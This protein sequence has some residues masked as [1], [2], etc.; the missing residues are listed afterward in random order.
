MENTNER[1]VVRVKKP[2]MIGAA[3][4]LAAVGLQAT[5][6]TCASLTDTYAALQTAGSCTIGDKTFSDFTFSSATVT[7]TGLLFTTVNDVAGE[8][9][10]SFSTS[11]LFAAGTAAADLSIGFTVATTSGKKLIDSAEVTQT[12]SAFG[13][14]YGTIGETVCL[15]S[16]LVTCP[17]GDTL[18][19][20]TSSGALGTDLSDSITFTNQSLVGISKDLFVTGGGTG[21]A[22]IS[23]FTDTVNQ[24][25]TPEPGFYGVLAGGLAGIF[26][27][28]KRR[29]KKT[30]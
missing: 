2:F 17:K 10:F 16:P 24:S 23:N 21:F 5:P 6:V 26:M 13:G 14:G 11:Q 12:G 18:S 30:A 7:N 19:M 28:A 27:F 22:S 25:A 20:A 15:G 29:S 9:G 3:L 8:Y 1:K 4:L